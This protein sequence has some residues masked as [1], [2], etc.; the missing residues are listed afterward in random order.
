MP[1]LPTFC[2]LAEL[3]GW[4]HADTPPQCAYI[5]MS[6]GQCKRQMSHKTPDEAKSIIAQ[7]LDIFT[8]PSGKHNDA[9]RLFELLL[10]LANIHLCGLH[11]KY[12]SNAKAQWLKEFAE[13]KDS[14]TAKVKECYNLGIDHTHT[15]EGGEDTDESDLSGVRHTSNERDSDDS[16]SGGEAGASRLSSQFSSPTEL[17]RR[18]FTISKSEVAK[19]VTSLLEKPIDN[20]SSPPGWIYV[21]CPVYLPG[22]I[23]VGI[24][25]KQ[26]P[27]LKRF[28]KH[29]ACYREVKVLT[30]RLIPYVY[31]VEQLMLT[32]FSNNHYMLE[33]KCQGCKKACHQELLNI[34]EKTLLRCLKKWISFVETCPYNKEGKLTKEAKERLPLP[35]SKIYL[36]EKPTRRHLTT[37]PTPKKE[38]GEKNTSISPLPILN[39]ANSTSET[40]HSRVQEVELDHDDLCAAVGDLHLTPSR[41]R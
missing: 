29:K 13:Q 41:R 25:R 16:A 23:K 30:T 37:T 20:K 21:I 7:N 15:G 32:E 17:L 9:S 22:T 36:G 6:G 2:S 3:A 33:N 40:K 8:A 39:L 31:R 10:N 38:R 11:K 28:P 35:A 5:V 18:T 1:S 26:H 14:I 27:E 4:T 12:N 34:D 24:T 19:D